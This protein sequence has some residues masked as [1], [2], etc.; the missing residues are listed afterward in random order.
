MPILAA[1]FARTARVCRPIASGPRDLALLTEVQGRQLLRDAIR[2]QRGRSQ[3]DS[4]A[5]AERINAEGKQDVGT[6]SGIR[7]SAERGQPGG[8]ASGSVV[9]RIHHM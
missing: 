4:G 5:S 2:G 7:V 9:A 8:C 3:S 1:S 6:S